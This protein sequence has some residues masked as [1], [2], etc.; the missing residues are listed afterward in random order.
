MKNR[1]C[2]FGVL[3]AVFMMTAGAAA[4]ADDIIARGSLK[5][6]KGVLV[7]ID[8]LSME[9]VKAGLTDDLLKRGLEQK[10]RTYGIKVLEKQDPAAPVYLYADITLNRA[11]D[12]PVYVYSVTLSLKQLAYLKRDSNIQLAVPTWALTRNGVAGEKVFSAAIHRATLELGDKFCA[13]L[14]AANGK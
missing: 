9:A 7:G 13:A 12:A 1:S 6:V 3:C 4:A 2:A 10:L 8:P 5:G 14:K 11:K